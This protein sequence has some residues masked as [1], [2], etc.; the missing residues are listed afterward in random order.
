MPKLIKDKNLFSCQCSRFDI[1]YIVLVR[2]N[3]NNQG[4]AESIENYNQA[5][6]AFYLRF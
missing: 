2:T 3:Q 1:P 5:C 6:R 4:R